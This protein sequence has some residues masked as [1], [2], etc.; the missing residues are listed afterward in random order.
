MFFLCLLFYRSSIYI[1]QLTFTSLKNN[2]IHLP[3]YS[4]LGVIKKKAGGKK[5]KLLPSKK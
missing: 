4:P 2:S 5:N 1:K 3:F